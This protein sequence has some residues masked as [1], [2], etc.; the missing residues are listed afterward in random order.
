VQNSNPVRRGPVSD[1]ATVRRGI[2]AGFGVE[3]Y[4]LALRGLRGLVGK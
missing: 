2:V 1:T 3:G 4:Y